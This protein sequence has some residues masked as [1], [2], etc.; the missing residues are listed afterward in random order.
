[1]SSVGQVIRS[2]RTSL[3]VARAPQRAAAGLVS[4]ADGLILSQVIHRPHIDFM[5]LS[6]NDLT[7]ATQ[8]VTEAR[9]RLERQRELI[10]HLRG[11]GRDMGEAETF[12]QTEV[13]PENGTG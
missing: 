5:A 1:V 8:R 12:L 4:C 13:D 2:E 9:E 3:R 6:D 7:N 11:E 10:Q